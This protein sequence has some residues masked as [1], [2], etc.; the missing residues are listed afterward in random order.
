MA[1]SLIVNGQ[2]G[3][4]ETMA[5]EK[6]DIKHMED[7]EIEKGGGKKETKKAKEGRGFNKLML[8]IAPLAVI[9][10]AAGGYFGYSYLS[11]GK[12]KAGV[13]GGAAREEKGKTIL[14][15]FDPFVV[16]LSEP[17]RYL[18]VTMQFEIASESQQALVAEKVPI[19]RD[20]IIT[21]ISNQ[22]YEYFSSPEG[23]LQL[24]DE[25]LLR[26]N[27]LFGKEMFRNL[28]FTDFVM[29]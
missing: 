8:I 18:K 1:R 4:V 25:I 26:T 2:E 7:Q 14:V 19:L 24:K 11:G 6:E 12:G 15:S 29:Q 27:Q 22:T 16:N 13:S 28:Y 17:G 9:A 21:L 5:A 23:K 3:G 20:L 10:L